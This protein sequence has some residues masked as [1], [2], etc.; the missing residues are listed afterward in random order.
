MLSLYTYFLC[1]GCFLSRCQWKLW[2]CWF[3]NDIIFAQIGNSKGSFFIPF[4]AVGS[5]EKIFFFI[6]ILNLS[7]FLLASAF[8]PFQFCWRLV[9]SLD[10][11]VSK[12][13]YYV[14][15]AFGRS[16]REKYLYNKVQKGLELKKKKKTGTKKTFNNFIKKLF[17]Y[18]KKKY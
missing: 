14:K 11:I 10:Y 16:Y 2:K 12:N 3:S 17:V 13:F 5:I 1:L 15:P 7:F 18:K 8:P 4:C 9:D 6:F